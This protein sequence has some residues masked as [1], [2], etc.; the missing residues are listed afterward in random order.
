MRIS[1]ENCKGCPVFDDNE[2]QENMVANNL[3]NKKQMVGCPREK[4][5]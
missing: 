1:K 4:N 2:H 5:G 3:C